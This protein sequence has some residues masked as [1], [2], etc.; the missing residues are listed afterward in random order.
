VVVIKVVSAQT[1]SV[2]DL[3]EHCNFSTLMP[4]LG[5]SCLSLLPVSIWDVSPQAGGIKARN[6][7]TRG[8]PTSPR[9]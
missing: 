6:V 2:G 7:V 4:K 9:F 8:V 1:S 5:V 3:E